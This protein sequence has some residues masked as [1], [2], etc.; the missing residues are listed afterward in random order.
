MKYVFYDENMYGYNWD[1]IKAAVD[2]VMRML[3]EGKWTYK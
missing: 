2:E 1:A 3:K